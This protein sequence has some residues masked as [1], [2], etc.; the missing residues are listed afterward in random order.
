MLHGLMCSRPGHG[1]LYEAVIELILMR[2]L[3]L[4]SSSEVLCDQVD[5]CGEKTHRSCLL[6]RMLRRAGVHG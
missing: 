4:Y 5:L 1:D 6:D 2:E 3:D